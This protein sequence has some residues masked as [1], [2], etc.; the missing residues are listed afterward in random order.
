V[1]TTAFLTVD[2]TPFLPALAPPV[3]VIAA[4]PVAAVA[5]LPVRHYVAPVRTARSAPAPVQPS[6]RQ[7]TLA[8]RMSATAGDTSRVA[9]AVVQRAAV[10]RARLQADAARAQQRAER[11][12][13]QATRAPQRPP[14]KGRA[15]Q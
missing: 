3:R 7:A 5:S 11:V 15:G 14:Q 8:D 9:R 2:P 10:L 4:R 1:D 13:A 6:A 12:V